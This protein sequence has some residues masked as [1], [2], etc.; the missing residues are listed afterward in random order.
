[1]KKN[2]CVL[3]L[4]LAALS[5]SA[6]S[7]ES[8]VAESGEV[9]AAYEIGAYEALETDEEE[10]A[11]SQNLSS[12]ES[13]LAEETKASGD[14]TE[15]EDTAICR[16]PTASASGD[17]IKFTVS[18]QERTYPNEALEDEIKL[19]GSFQT[20]DIDEE[21]FDE[22]KNAVAKEN[23]RAMD[24]YVAMWESEVTYFEEANADEDALTS[25]MWSITV[26]VEPARYDGRVFSYT[27]VTDTYLGGAH[28]NAYAA[29]KNFDA[30]TGA[31]LEFQD[32]A[33]D[34]DGV[35]EFVLEE[36]RNLKEE[37]EGLEYFEGYEES[38]NAAFYPENADV[39]VSAEDEVIASL[40]LNWLIGT[41]GVYIIFNPYD[42]APYA[43][44]RISVQIPKSSGLL[45]NGLF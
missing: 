44:G 43:A 19:L 8:S 37:T 10:T 36:L 7:P 3:T 40:T 26:T 27:R 21:G 28:P 20:I 16:Y 31:E 29:C 22:L 13:Q 42:I 2:L 23:E 4:A 18:T 39:S 14:G 41:D 12:E 9:T 33:A 34:Y 30:V 45:N 15:S 35:Y 38:I 25:S 6:C 32:A 24:D 17:G 11:G 5:V 1:M